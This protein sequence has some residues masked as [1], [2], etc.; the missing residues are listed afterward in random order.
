MLKSMNFLRGKSR[1]IVSGGTK[2]TLLAPV[3]LGL[4]PGIFWQRV[5][6]LF[7][8]LALLLHKCLFAQD[9]RDKPKNDWCW[10]RGLSAFCTFFKYPSPDTS[11][12]PSPSRGEGLGLPR[13]WCDKILGTEPSMTGG[14]GA[15]SFGRSMI[16]MLGVLA[17]VGVLSVGGI[18]GYSKAMEKYKLYTTFRDLSFLINEIIPYSQQF[19]SYQ[20]STDLLPIIKSLNVT[21]VSFEDHET[22]LSDP[23]NNKFIAQTCSVSPCWK[24]YYI[25]SDNPDLNAKFCYNIVSFTQNFPQIIYRVAINSGVH[26]YGNAHCDGKTICLQNQ[27]IQQIHDYCA[28]LCRENCILQIGFE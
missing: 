11:V 7:Y 3:I 5:S 19:M 23:W 28:D 1:G 10:G 8:K 24:F 27:N 15:N 20:P 14:K 6:N 13:P 25:L 4:V 16:E 21:P 17:I 2:S 22:Y 18:A 12:S 26:L 9:S